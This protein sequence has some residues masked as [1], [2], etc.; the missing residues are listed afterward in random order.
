MKWLLLKAVLTNIVVLST[1]SFA[2]SGFVADRAAFETACASLPLYSDND[3][4]VQSGKKKLSDKAKAGVNSI[5]DS[6]EKHGDGDRRKLAYVLASA[7]R[8]S[9][10]TFES[11]KEVP[12]C[13]GD[14]G[15]IERAIGRLLAKQGRDPSEN[16]AAPNAQ[17]KRYYGRGFVQ[18]T[19][20]YNYDSMTKLLGVDL[21]NTPDLALD[22]GIAA[23]ILVV[24]M[25]D[26]FFTNRKLEDYFND[27]SE[28]WV[29]ARAIVN[30]GSSN[31]GMMGQHAKD[32][33]ACLK[34]ATGEVADVPPGITHP[35]PRC[36][37]VDPRNKRKR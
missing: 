29:C 37:L 6:W 28:E 8:E 27:R 32:I 31:W 2:Q 5:F 19:K 35:R 16:Y 1:P 14:E 33:L 3:G 20:D 9:S 11:I 15:C 30:P 4:K 23:T 36:A 13:K 7:F 21:V 24:G 22:P 18:L 10:Y 25:R 26:G 17:G 34:P 12:S